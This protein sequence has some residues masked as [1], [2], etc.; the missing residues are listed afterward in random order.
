MLRSRR[1]KPACLLMVALLA[2]CGGAQPTEPASYGMIGLVNTGAAPRTEEAPVEE[3]APP[4]PSGPIAV[5]PPPPPGTVGGRPSP[6]L[7][8][9]PIEPAFAEAVGRIQKA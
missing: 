2:G 6:D 7:T 9:A 4:E 8:D 3:V 1:V 5:E